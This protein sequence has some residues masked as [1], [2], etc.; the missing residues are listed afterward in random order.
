MSL[1]LP[2]HKDLLQW[3]LAHLLPR[4]NIIAGRSTSTSVLRYTPKS[5]KKAPK[6]NLY[7]D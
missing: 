2:G 6:Y 3:R 7:S 1:P 5:F 4:W